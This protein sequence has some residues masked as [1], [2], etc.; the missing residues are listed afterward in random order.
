MDRIF[1]SSKVDPMT[2][3]KG[4]AIECLLVIAYASALLLAIYGGEKRGEQIS[5]THIAMLAMMCSY[6]AHGKDAFAGTV[7]P[8]DEISILMHECQP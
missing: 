5:K 1:L 2:H 8:D 7:I 6:T 3:P 4:N